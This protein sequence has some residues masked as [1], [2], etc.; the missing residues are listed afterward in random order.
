MSIPRAFIKASIALAL[1]SVTLV[2]ASA[3]GQ[4]PASQPHNATAVSARKP[5]SAE[6]RVAAEDSKPKDLHSEIEAVKAEYAA[7]RE[8]LRTMEEQQ[9]LLLEQVERLQRRLDGAAATHVSIT[10]QPNAV[11]AMAPII[12][13]HAGDSAAAAS[14]INTA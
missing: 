14:Q 12:A 3:S 5:G 8:L 10:S 9:K 1:T 13:P 2:T 7:V 11:A 4:S 6:N